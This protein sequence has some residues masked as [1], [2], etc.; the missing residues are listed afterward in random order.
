MNIFN[1]I[2]IW[3]SATVNCDAFLT[4]VWVCVQASVCVWVYIICAHTPTLICM[5]NIEETY[6][7]IEMAP[8][9]SWQSFLK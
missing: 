5:N 6:I 4:H 2:M 7:H 1:Y 9:L 8:T 3:L